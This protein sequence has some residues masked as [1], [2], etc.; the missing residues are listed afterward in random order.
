MMCAAMH[1]KLANMAILPKDRLYGPARMRR[2]F[3]HVFKGL[4]AVVAVLDDEIAIRCFLVRCGM[5]GVRS[6]AKA[7]GE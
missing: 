4:W 1:N 7:A 5:N 6:G 2:P 3:F